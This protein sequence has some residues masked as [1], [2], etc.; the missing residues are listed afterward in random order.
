ML[1]SRLAPTPSGYLHLGNAFS[2]VLTWLIVRK[3]HGHL[4]LRIDDLDRDR[5]KPEY[6]DDIFTTLEWLGINYD[7]GARSGQ[8]C[9]LHWSQRRRLHDYNAALMQLAEQGDVFTCDCSRSLLAQTSPTGLYPGTCRTKHLPLAT[10][11]TAWRVR[12]PE[13]TTERT[14]EQASVRFHD[15]SAREIS[16]NVASEIGD[17][18]VRRRDGIPAYH[19]A[20]LVDDTLDGITFIVRGADLLTSTAAQVFLAKRLGLSPFTQTTFLHHP[21]LLESPDKKLS[22]SHQSLSLRA[23]RENGTS[24]EE[25]LSQIASLLGITPHTTGLQALLEVFSLDVLR[26]LSHR[27]AFPL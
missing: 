9:L 12:V 21:L 11:N 24:S 1:R 16:L 4:H 14:T 5:A 15:A 25:V 19:I 6:Y 27:S 7:S 17:F 3:Q 8:D 26:V 13:Q 2:F 23:M 20:S 18:I 10:P 22:K